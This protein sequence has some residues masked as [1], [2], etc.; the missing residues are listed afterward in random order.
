MD[1]IKKK[2]QCCDITLCFYSK[3][4]L[5]HQCLKFILERHSTCFGRSFRPSSGVQDCTY[6][7]RHLSNR[8]C[9]LHASMQSAWDIRVSS[10]FYYTNILRCTALWTL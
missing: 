9:W 8:Y 5:M 7:N 4:N 2:L 6:S 1:L 10:W 3:T